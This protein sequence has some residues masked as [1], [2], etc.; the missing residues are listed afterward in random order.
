MYANLID[1]CHSTHNTQVKFIGEHS[2]TAVRSINYL[3]LTI[4]VSNDLRVSW[5]LFMKLSHNGVHL[6]YLSSVPLPMKHAA[7]SSGGHGRT[8]RRKR[9]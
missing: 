5:E 9:R 3:D 1:L 4:S 6:P 7:T 8:R 2:D